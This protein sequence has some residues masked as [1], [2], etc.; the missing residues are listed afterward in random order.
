MGAAR[1]LRPLIVQ[2]KLENK[3]KCTQQIKPFFKNIRL[4]YPQL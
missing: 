3:N 2:K 1:Y 4:S